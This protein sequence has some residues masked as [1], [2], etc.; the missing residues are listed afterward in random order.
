M[1]LTS[2]EQ[3]WE[4]LLTAGPALT[5]VLPLAVSHTPLPA[6]AAILL[7]TTLHGAQSRGQRWPLDTSNM[8]Q[9]CWCCWE[10]SPM[11]PSDSCRGNEVCQHLL[12][13]STLLDSHN[14]SAGHQHCDTLWLYIGL[15]IIN[16]CIKQLKQNQVY[17]SKQ[18]IFSGNG[19]K[20]P[21]TPLMIL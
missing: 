7:R 10:N 1:N 20:I 5:R 11:D 8:N 4:P 2:P 17:S 14:M 3:A 21:Q 9:G 6:Q 19:Q 13:H 12:S 16:I 15:L 18:M